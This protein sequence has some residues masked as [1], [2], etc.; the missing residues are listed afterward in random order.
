MGTD[1]PPR[2]PFRVS[3]DTA[4]SLGSAFTVETF[5]GSSV[6]QK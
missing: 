1:S 5:D 4:V 3:E 6:G 2:Y